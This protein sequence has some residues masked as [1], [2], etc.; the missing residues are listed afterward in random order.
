M[1]VD[2]ELVMRV[3]ISSPRT[4]RTVP[5]G[6]LKL[7]KNNPIVIVLEEMDQSQGVWIWTVGLGV[8]KNHD[9]QIFS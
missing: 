3:P 6:S 2:I 9:H 5:R 7:S 4:P 1:T 8:Q